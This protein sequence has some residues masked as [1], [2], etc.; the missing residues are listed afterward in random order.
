MYPVLGISMAALGFWEALSLWSFWRSDYSRNN[1][2]PPVLY[3]SIKLNTLESN[4]RG[5]LSAGIMHSFNILPIEFT[6]GFL[7]GVKLLSSV[8]VFHIPKSDNCHWYSCIQTF[9]PRFRILDTIMNEE[10]HIS[11][12]VSICGSLKRTQYVS[13]QL[14]NFLTGGRLILVHVSISCLKHSAKI[15]ASL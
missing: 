15:S 1:R 3:R 8:L 13:T 5:A 2:V 10:S 9:L 4:T 14:S 6:L 7:D 12:L 11:I